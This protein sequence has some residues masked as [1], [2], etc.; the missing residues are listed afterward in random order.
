MKAKTGFK[1]KGQDVG[2]PEGKPI[3]CLTLGDLLEATK[4]VNSRGEKGGQLLELF[5]LHAASKK[6]RSSAAGTLTPTWEELRMVARQGSA[7]LACRF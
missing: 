6:H 4:F 2:G 7:C 1:I 3:W 5:V